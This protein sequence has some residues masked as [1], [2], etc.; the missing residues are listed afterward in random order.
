MA[1]TASSVTGTD[2]TVIAVSS[3]EID[4]IIAL[5]EELK[6][7]VETKFNESHGIVG[8]AWASGSGEA[9]KVIGWGS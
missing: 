3:G 4:S 2:S 5:R 1:R 7:E 8:A 6:T 9:P